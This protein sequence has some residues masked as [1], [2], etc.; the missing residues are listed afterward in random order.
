MID[1]LIRFRDHPVC[2][3]ASDVLLVVLL[4]WSVWNTRIANDNHSETQRLAVAAARSSA[5]T[6]QALC[7]L[8]GDLATRVRSSQAF[9]T[10]HPQGF[11]GIS[12]AVIQQ[13]IDNE[14]RT[15]GTLRFLR[16]Q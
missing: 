11:A 7:A 8:R 4:A 9:L 16:C 5:Q 15:I 1:R 14:E 6:H 3:V 12:A 13:G 10:T 2:R